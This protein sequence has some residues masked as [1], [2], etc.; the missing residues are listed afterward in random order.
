MIQFMASLIQ[1]PAQHMT[2]QI[3]LPKSGMHPINE[4]SQPAT[5]TVGLTHAVLIALVLRGKLIMIEQQTALT[6][7]FHLKLKNK[8]PL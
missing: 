5:H 8:K 2:V 4:H 6:Y 3:L 7:S 1:A